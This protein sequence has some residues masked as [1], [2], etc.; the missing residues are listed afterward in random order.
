MKKRAA[1]LAPLLLSVALAGGAAA[2]GKKAEQDIDEGIRNEQPKQQGA[3][4]APRT[5]DAAPAGDPL[6]TLRL[7]PQQYTRVTE[8]LKQE[9]MEVQRLEKDASLTPADRKKRRIE[10]VR[11]G[12]AKLREIL[13]K[14][15]YEEYRRMI[16]TA[17]GARPA[18]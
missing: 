15:Q 10:I 17:K 11:E 6:A 18:E 14:G 12:D 2:E 3:K 16:S 1:L 13:D 9:Y 8:M 4:D 7:T 5:P